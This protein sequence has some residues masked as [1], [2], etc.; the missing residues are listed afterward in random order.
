LISLGFTKHSFIYKKI[1]HLIICKQANKVT[2]HCSESKIMSEFSS[3]E[4][5]KVTRIILCTQNNKNI[6]WPPQKIF[7]YTTHRNITYQNIKPNYV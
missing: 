2:A 4:M 1:K 3:Y 5:V 7:A 6:Q